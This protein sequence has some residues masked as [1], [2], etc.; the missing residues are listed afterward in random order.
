MKQKRKNLK[1]Q[2]H[3]V[4]QVI[5][6]LAHHKKVRLQ[7]PTASGKTFIVAQIVEKLLTHPAFM[8]QKNTF[9]FIAPSNGSLDH[10]GYEKIT[11]YLA[12]GWVKFFHTH[13][14]GTSGGKTVKSNYLN[15]ID[16]LAENTIYFIGWSL[17]KKGSNA[18]LLDSEKNN[19]QRVIAATHKKQ[20]KIILIIDEAHREWSE[21]EKNRKDKV[22][23]DFIHSQLKYSKILQVS[24]TLKDT[25]EVNDVVITLDNVREEEAIRQ[26]II[27]NP[28]N[29]EAVVEDKYD[30]VDAITQM[31]DNAIAKEE[32]I[33]QAY[34]L[35]KIKSPLQPLTLIQIPDVGSTKNKQYDDYYLEKVEYILQKKNYRE[36]IDYAVWL[37]KRKTFKDKN[38]IA[39]SDSMIKFL[40]FKQAVATGW[41]VPRAEILVKLREPK[42]S[43]HRFEI[44]T[45]G[46]ILRNPFFKY[47]KNKK[48]PKANDLVNNAYVFTADEA[49]QERIEHE[50]FTESKAKAR[51]SFP[52][53]FKGKTSKIEINKVI[54][55]PKY[56]IKET[57]LI[58]QIVEIFLQ[59]TMRK[60][61]TDIVPFTAQRMYETHLQSRI[62]NKEVSAAAVL[63]DE[64][65]QM[66]LGFKQNE[67][68]AQDSLLD[69]YIKYLY[70]I[71]A[72]SDLH[73]KIIEEIADNHLQEHRI[74]KKEFYKYI[75]LN[76][77]QDIFL[78][79]MSIKSFLQKT[80]NKI[81]Q[82]SFEATYPSYTLPLNM[83]YNPNRVENNWDKV[84][85]YELGIA[86]RKSAHDSKLERYF[87]D[88][89]KTCF[90]GDNNFQ[91]FRNQVGN[92]CYEVNYFNELNH[93]VA[94]FFPDFILKY[95]DRII[96]CEVKGEKEN[97][98][99]QNTEVKMK[100]LYKFQ[101]Q[102]ASNYSLYI[103]KITGRAN[104]TSSEELWVNDENEVKQKQRTTLSDSF[105][106]LK[107]Q[108][109]KDQLER[110]FLIKKEQYDSYE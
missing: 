56:E 67:P 6:K 75:I 40:I 52:L 1:F 10:Q 89:L 46:R 107:H 25:D 62:K 91:V 28:S 100:T 86:S 31:I 34:Q 84:N 22:R 19:L 57:Y 26:K 17:I 102:I 78:E 9:L 95:Y 79:N 43:S 64:D 51:K 23:N 11:K 80:I 4:R 98:I 104:I 5:E 110:Q 81:M 27:I 21:N 37:D 71:S 53:S 90:A 63:G 8:G 58:K 24:A 7:A 33:K 49:Y 92:D 99:D 83:Q 47:Y 39:A 12:D 35:L 65:Y 14:I 77:D 96:I 42:N 61:I 3:A 76:F 97:D 106:R 20:H 73:K 108:Y 48:F 32:E 109:D 44:Q 105:I 101:N 103:W 72:M 41:D 55:M 36:K 82:D 94:S 68:T 15:N 70:K 66:N 29:D 45:L 87:Y 93:R 18:L 59:E 16:Y 85:S 30:S 50:E 54:F 74:K 13:Y 69:I 88:F 38:K 2:E 60:I